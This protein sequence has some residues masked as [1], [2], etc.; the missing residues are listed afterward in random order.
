MKQYPLWDL[1]AALAFIEIARERYS[2]MHLLCYRQDQ[3]DIDGRPRETW[4]V[5]YAN[6]TCR[7]QNDLNEPTN[8][9]DW[10]GVVRTLFNEWIEEWQDEGHQLLAAFAAGEAITGDV[11]LAARQTRYVDRINKERTC[12]TEPFRPARAAVK[13]ASP[14]E[15]TRQ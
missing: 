7:L 11:T 15:R 2:L 6:R 1:D 13:M 10:W 8:G 12:A 3:N 14:T 9:A 5:M 4:W